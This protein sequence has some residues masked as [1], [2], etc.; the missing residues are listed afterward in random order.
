MLHGQ[1]GE[2]RQKQAGYE[3][4]LPPSE[5]KHGCEMISGYSVRA[6]RK[7]GMTRRPLASIGTMGRCRSRRELLVSR[8]HGIEIA[9]NFVGARRGILEVVHALD[10]LLKI[11]VVGLDLGGLHPVHVVADFV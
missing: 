10:D 4:A 5:M 11:V 8:R 1:T 9:R 6:M 7:D 3:Q 2:K